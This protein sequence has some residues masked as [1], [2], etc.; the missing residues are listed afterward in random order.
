[1]IAK[2]WLSYKTYWHPTPEQH[3]SIVDGQLVIIPGK[4][5][6]SAILFDVCEKRNSYILNR[7]RLQ[8]ENIL[9]V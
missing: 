6:T 4:H 9:F 2:N 7:N 1:M 5:K 3:Q 8:I